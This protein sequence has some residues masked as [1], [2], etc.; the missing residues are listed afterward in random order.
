[1]QLSSKDGT[2]GFLLKRKISGEKCRRCIDF[3]TG[4]SKDANCPVCYGMGWV[5][6]YYKAIP[7][8]YINV[9]PSGSTNKRDLEVQGL[10]ADTQI[11][12]RAIADPLLSRV[13]KSPLVS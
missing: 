5:G 4:E 11:A 3:G 10:V 7:C 6:G 9:Q 1:M 2:T 8:F 13:R 12:G